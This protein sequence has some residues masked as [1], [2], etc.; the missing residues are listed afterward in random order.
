MNTYLALKSLH[1][2]GVVLFVGNIVVTGWWKAQAD[3]TRHPAINAFAQ[4]QVTLTD[5]LFTFGGVL[6]AVAAG[7][8]DAQSRGLPLDTPWLLWGQAL[9]IASGLLWIGILVPVQSRQARLACGFAAGGPIPDAYWR[10]NRVAI[11]T[12]I[13]A[14]PL[15]LANLWVLV[16][17]DPVRAERPLADL[18]AWL[19]A[20]LQRTREAAS[21][22][23]D[24][25]EL[26]RRYL[27]IL[28][29]R[30]GARLRVVFDVP[31]ALL[32]RPFPL[33][34][35]Q[36]LVENAV[37][38]GIEPK[39][40]GGELRIAAVEENGRLRL[41]VSDT[42]A[43]LRESGG[44]LCAEAG[45]QVRGAD[46][47]RRA[48]HPHADQGTRGAARSRS[49]LAGASRHPRQRPFRHG[50]APRR[51]RPRAAQPARPAGDGCGEP[52]LRAPVQAD[53]ARI[54]AASRC[55]PAGERSSVAKRGAAA[56]RM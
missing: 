26:L 41:L 38:H 4:R 3:R 12:G 54:S 45:G 30:F 35:L 19:R 10:L 21:T 8:A 23:G 15:P 40:G 16:R 48:A 50:G 49:L 39:V 52:R 42:G 14:T 34:L 7:Y 51:Q 43:G 47:Q 53:V 31:E 27:D 11:A 32:A 22:L 18:I 25:I 44:R 36:P 5:W 33:L 1:I 28:G 37:T 55:R 29:L 17:S 20:T 13:T 24:G 2:L 56:K 9:F 46:R 6:L